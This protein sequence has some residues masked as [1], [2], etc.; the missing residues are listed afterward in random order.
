MQKIFNRDIR[1]KDINGNNYPEWEEKR[2]GEVLEERNERS[3]TKNQYPILTS[4][5]QGIFFQEEYFDKQTASINNIG[6]KIIHKGD[7]TYRSMSDT[8][9]FTFNIQNL[10]EKGM[11]SPAYPVLIANNESINTFLEHYL[12]HAPFLLK[13]IKQLREG[14]TRFALSVSKF[15]KLRILLPNED[16]T[17][18]ITKLFQLIDNLNIKNNL[19][20]LLVKNFKEGLLQKMFI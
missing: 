4:S 6:Y 10:I 5:N 2:L 13:Q 12:N 7:L 17:K 15:K 16:E 20:I 14:G 3:T 18:K 8:G 19:E 1:F 9:S 11:I